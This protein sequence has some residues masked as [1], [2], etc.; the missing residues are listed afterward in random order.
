MATTAEKTPITTVTPPGARTIELPDREIQLHEMPDLTKTAPEVEY[1]TTQPRRSWLRYLGVGVVTAAVAVG[2]GL[3][4][5][6]WMNAR[7]PAVYEDYFAQPYVRPDA[8]VGFTA[9]YSLAREHLAQAPGGFVPSVYETYGGQPY[10]RPDSPVTSTYS[11]ARE[12]LAQTPGGFPFVSTYSASTS[13]AGEHLAQAPLPVEVAYA[14]SLA[15]EHLAQAPLPVEVAYA[16]S[17]AGEHLAQ[18]PGGF[19]D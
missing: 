19:P 17:L 11:L 3:G 5:N 14:D 18:T 4:I 7:T 13:L 15:G 8:P 2:A 10:V 16:D 9:D 12:H 1:A 6:A